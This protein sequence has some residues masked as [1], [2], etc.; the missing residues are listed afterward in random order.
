MSKYVCLA[1]GAGFI[2]SHL[3][4]RL[5]LRSDILKIVLVDNFWTGRM[6]NFAHVDDDRV[7]FERRDVETVSGSE[8]FDEVYHLASPASPPWYMADPARTVSANVAG[9]LRLLDLLKPGGKFCYTSSSEVYG[10]PK[11]SPQPES[12]YGSVDCTGPRAAYDE[13]K[14]CTEALLFGYQRTQGLDLR[15]VRPFNVFGP[16]TRPDDGRAVSNFIANAIS[17][18]P[19]EIYG[20]GSQTRSWGYVDDIVDG[21]EQFFWQTDIDYNG[22]LN[23]GND[24][25]VTVLEIAHFVRDL[26]PGSRIVFVDPVPQDPSN[27]R[28]D[29]T[30]ANQH[31]P[32]WSCKT[33]YKAGIKQTLEWFQAEMLRS[34]IRSVEFSLAPRRSKPHELKVA[35]I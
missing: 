4:D 7:V 20:D 16:R 5:L 10:D 3:L 2:G 9:A 25:E 28:P 17:G 24:T 13:G 29:L 19:I 23:I 6:E 15:I 18:R 32:G 34:K 11:V 22:P 8:L 26:V 30:L 14:R 12:Y 21:F 27:R 35:S 31:L 1:G 33:D